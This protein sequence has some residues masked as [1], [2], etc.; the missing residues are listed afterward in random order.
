MLT[1]NSTYVESFLR[2]AGRLAGPMCPQ[3]PGRPAPILALEEGGICAYAYRADSR[4]GARTRSLWINVWTGCQHPVEKPVGNK[5][6]IA[7]LR[8]DI[9]CP[10]DNVRQHGCRLGLL[11]LAPGSGLW[12]RLHVQLPGHDWSGGGA[13]NVP[14]LRLHAMSLARHWRAIW[15]MKSSSD[16]DEPP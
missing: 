3:R 13:R 11:E 6:E 9:S 12:F 2:L 15:G 8:A 10:L 14:A 5:G 4:T 7:H 16:A 1:V